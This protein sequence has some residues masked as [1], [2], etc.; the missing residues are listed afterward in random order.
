LTQWISKR[1]LRGSGQEE[2]KNK[3]YVQSRQYGST[4]AGTVQRRYYRRRRNGRRVNFITGPELGICLPSLSHLHES[5]KD[6]TLGQTYVEENKEMSFGMNWGRHLIP[7]PNHLFDWNCTEE[8]RRLISVHYNTYTPYHPGYL[9]LEEDKVE[10]SVETGIKSP[11]PEGT[12]RP[13]ESESHTVAMVVTLPP[14]KWAG[15]Y[16]ERWVFYTGA[17]AHITS[18]SRYMYN[19]HPT[20]QTITVAD[21][22]VYPVQSEGVHILVPWGI[23]ELR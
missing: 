21:G 20:K 5:T 18:N 8:Q 10:D 6:P 19:L 12:K 14:L 2:V 13:R 22:T 15:H 17:T 16:K 23:P 4:I 1:S 7:W 9:T 11:E 3:T